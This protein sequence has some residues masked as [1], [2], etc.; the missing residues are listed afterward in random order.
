MCPIMQD[1]VSFNA[2]QSTMFTVTSSPRFS[3]HRGSVD[4]PGFEKHKSSR[5]S[6]PRSASYVNLQSS[7]PQPLQASTEDGSGIKR[8]LSDLVLTNLE[9]RAWKHGP[10]PNV[11]HPNSLAEGFSVAELGPVR[12]D[13]K[14]AVSRIAVTERKSMT[15]SRRPTTSEGREPSDVEPKTRVISGPLR[16]LTQRSWYVPSRSPSPAPKDIKQDHTLDSN[17]FVIQKGDLQNG[18]HSRKSRSDGSDIPTVPQIAKVHQ[19]RNS[20][21]S[22]KRPLSALLGRPSTPFFDAGSQ[23][24]SLP[25]SFS[26]DRLPSTIHDQLHRARAAGSSVS[27]PSSPNTAKSFVSDTPR[28]KDELW[29]NFRSLDAEFQKSALPNDAAET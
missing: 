14:I 22:R 7:V 12:P 8:N 11:S 10:K 19:R 18:T 28:K 23:V 26:T 20:I 13:S 27:I 5:P 29:N 17:N 1:A 6:I 25:K 4:L 9:N 16:T 3:N 15:D 24:P 21:A 2:P